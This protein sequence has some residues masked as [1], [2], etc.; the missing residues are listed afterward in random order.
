MY[1]VAEFTGKPDVLA[2]RVQELA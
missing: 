1:G 2:G